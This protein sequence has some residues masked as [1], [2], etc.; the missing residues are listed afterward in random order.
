MWILERGP[1]VCNRRVIVPQVQKLTDPDYSLTTNDSGLETSLNMSWSQV[2]TP[3]PVPRYQ[4]LFSSHV[5]LLF[6][7]NETSLMDP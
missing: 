1:F 5:I 7:M 6:P 2:A 3:T 4:N